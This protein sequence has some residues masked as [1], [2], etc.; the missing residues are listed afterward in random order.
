LKIISICREND[1]IYTIVVQQNYQNL[2]GTQAIFEMGKMG[3]KNN[4]AKQSH[5]NA[6]K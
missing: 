4:D 1:R 3:N 2:S 6:T 5:N